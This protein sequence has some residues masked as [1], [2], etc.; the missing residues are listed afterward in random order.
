AEDLRET[1]GSSARRATNTVGKEA[2]I[3]CRTAERANFASGILNLPRGLAHQ[4]GTPR[5]PAGFQNAGCRDCAK[6]RTTRAGTR[7]SARVQAPTDGAGPSRFGSIDA[8]IR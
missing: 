2:D 8:G 4:S 1:P 7:Q 5:R 6:R 3:G